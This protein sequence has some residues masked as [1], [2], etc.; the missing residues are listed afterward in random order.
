MTVEQLK[1]IVREHPIMVFFTKDSNGEEYFDIANLDEYDIC[2]H[3]YDHDYGIIMTSQDKKY[4]FSATNDNI[5]GH[6]DMSTDEIMVYDGASPLPI[7]HK[8]FTV[9][10]YSDDKY[11]EFVKE[12][13]DK[14]INTNVLTLESLCKD[15]QYIMDSINNF[16][17]IRKMY[18]LE[19]DLLPMVK[20]ENEL[21]KD[22]ISRLL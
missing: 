22:I 17:K 10:E 14:Y 6:C 13:S 19:T 15:M 5:L 18:G 12:T 3:D 1:K 11:H 4:L 20:D 16:I 8:L 9:D 7:I 2:D 21:C